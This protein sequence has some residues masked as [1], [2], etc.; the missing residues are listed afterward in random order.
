MLAQNERSIDLADSY[1][2]ML[3]VRRM[4]WSDALLLI[5]GYVALD[6][7]SFFHPLYGLNITPWN[8]APAL[9]LI[10]LLRYGWKAALPLGFAVLLAEA[11]VRNL[12]IAVP[13]LVL[14]AAMLAVGYGAIGEILRRRLG[15]LG[16][17]FDR[18]GMLQWMGIVIVGILVTSLVFVLAL[19]TLGLI[20]SADWVQ[21]V[22]R[23][24]I[25]EGVGILVSMPL[26]W[27][28]LDEHGRAMLAATLRRRGTFW[29]VFVAGAA[30]WVAFGLGAES[31]FKYFYVLFLP[32]VWAAVRQGLT[33]AVLSAAAIQIG[34]IV[35]VQIQGFAAVTVFEIQT[36]TV[37]LALVGFFVGVVVDE[38]QRISAE[39]RQTLRLAAAGEMAGA[40]AHELNQ[41]L[42][43]LSAYGSACE[44]LLARGET[45]DQLKSAIR[46]M[47]SESF[48]AAEV[49]RRLRDF[50]RTG[51]TQ[52]EPV[53]VAELLPAAA[54]PF[55]ARA[56][57]AGVTLT[58]TPAPE[59]IVMADRPQIEVVI[60]NLLTNA[61]DAVA[62]QPASNRRVRLSAEQEGLGRV[63]IKVEDS[64]PGVSGNAA[65]RMF[66]PFISTKSSGLGLGLAIS[67]AIAEVHGGSLSA[68]VGSHGVFCLQLPLER[69]V[70]NA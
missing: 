5:A 30:L 60:R 14:I 12:P 33:G 15:G 61:F 51:T 26:L 9:G 66:E 53:S 21:A 46:L 17:F 49:V 1:T 35:A 11:W 20:P 48:R 4:H 3:T 44:E 25:G 28:L 45:G 55:L 24:W 38:Q 62:N 34:L 31:D 58:L 23:Y 42:T 56:V 68:E 8:P 50:F 29:D 10:F 16:I 13:V 69:K 59:G 22:G 27:M 70:S 6:W 47:V 43:A 18:A 37:V 39:L 36:L 54:A 67:R 57:Q 64:G 7:A 19:V 52:L 41:P 32:I 63:C 65:A 2:P 40:L